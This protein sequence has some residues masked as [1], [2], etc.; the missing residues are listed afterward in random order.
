MW[1]SSS[2]SLLITS[3]PLSPTI[4]FYSFLPQE[5]EVVCLSSFIPV[6]DLNQFITTTN[7]FCSENTHTQI[8]PFPQESV[9]LCICDTSTNTSFSLPIFIQLSTCFWTHPEQK[10]ITFTMKKL[11]ELFLKGYFKYLFQQ[12]EL[13]E[14]SFFYLSVSHF[15][16]KSAT[17]TISEIQADETWFRDTGKYW[18]MSGLVNWLKEWFIIHRTS[19]CRTNRPVLVLSLRVKTPS[20]LGITVHYEN[21]TQSKSLKMHVLA[22]FWLSE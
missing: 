2:F 6:C 17:D 20:I 3:L 18:N 11:T 8:L 21:V 13:C 7:F 10:L 1:N 12:G 15:Q 4:C 22:L 19:Q 9:Y 16:F 5:N 14:H